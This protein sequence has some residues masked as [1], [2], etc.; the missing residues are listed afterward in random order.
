MRSTTHKRYALFGGIDNILAAY[1]AGKITLVEVGAKVGFS[2]TTVSNDLIAA[3]GKDSIQKARSERESTIRKN[4]WIKTI[5]SGQTL[6]LAYNTAAAYLSDGTLKQKEHSA[7]FKTIISLAETATG[8]PAWIWFSANKICRMDG[9]KGT[10]IIRYA[11]P[12]EDKAEY[13]IDRY[14]FKITPA[15]VKGVKAFL[16]CLTAARRISYYIFPSAKLA[17]IQSLNLKFDKH[18]NSKYAPFLAKVEVLK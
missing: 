4:R 16:F 1:S 3:F 17:K 13:R 5:N 2:G 9:L 10:V 7:E 8:K 6:K 18:E 12:K 15:Q 11:E 14:R